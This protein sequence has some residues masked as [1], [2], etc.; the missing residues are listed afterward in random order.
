MATVG[1][2]KV[3]IKAN[4]YRF[5]IYIGM[6]LLIM[7]LS[8]IF[9]IPVLRQILGFIFLTFV[10][11]W[12]I[13]YILKLNKL[14]MTEKL[15][16]CV[17]LSIAF[18]MF[19]GLLI[20]M[21]YP[22]FGYTTPLSTYSVLISFGVITLILAVIAYIRNINT[23]F[24]NISALKLN[25]KE[26]SYLLIPFIF[27]LLSIFGMLVMNS[28]NNNVILMILLCLIAA[29]VIF[30]AIKHNNVPEKIY[31]LTI[32][33]IGIGVILLLALRSNYII[34]VDIHSEYSVF[35]QTLE[36]ERWQILSNSILDSCLSISI[37]PTVYQS[38]LHINSE[39]LFKLLYPLLFSISPLVVYLITKKYLNGFYSFLAS[40]FFISQYYF[41]N[42]EISPR[43][44]I[45]ILFFAL[46]FLVLFANELN[47]GNKYILFIIFAAACIVSHYATTYIFFII[48]V[49]TWILMRIS[50]AIFSTQ[51]KPDVIIPQNTHGD[52]LNSRPAIWS[53][54]RQFLTFIPVAIVFIML[55]IWYSLVTG[56]AFRNGVGFISQTF[57]SLQNF[58][59]MEN[60]GASGT[61]LGVGFYAE[62]IPQQINFVVSWLTVI[63]II[64]GLL[65]V[66][67]KNS[68]FHFLDKNYQSIGLVIDMEYFSLSV[69]CCLILGISLGLPYIF[70]G[71]DLNRTYTLMITILSSFFI[72]GGMFIS[73]I[74]HNKF[75]YL[76]IIIVLIP[77]FLCS[78]GFMYQIFGNPQQIILNSTGVQYDL[79]Y[80]HDQELYADYWLNNN[81]ILSTPIYTDF[82]GQERLESGTNISVNSILDLEN[83]LN[84]QKPL[85]GYIYLGYNAVV[86]GYLDVL[87]NVT[88]LSTEVSINTYSSKIT[89]NDK[90]YSN[91]E[92]DL[93][94]YK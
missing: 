3:V 29:F 92:T 47:A 19:T 52:N 6:F 53:R 14:E 55:F 49:L 72:I 30:I 84:G 24:G 11:G 66:V 56:P 76:V 59:D 81:R 22:L 60:R 32:I 4:T 38:F 73:D 63:F 87:N 77:Y 15:V 5:F 35:Q 40:I 65:D 91:G 17:G 46:A 13:L 41:V 25:V 57:N 58:F 94:Y 69:V 2:T 33:L 12:L 86:D 85:D 67:Y 79:Y 62:T 75:A 7:S 16:L 88:K 36:N 50:P 83:Y 70:I 64:F 23:V 74:I 44:V 48:L 80:F 1:K 28:T 90:I 54:S 39:Y 8:I 89:A 34:G 37:L 43:T 71:Y 18:I 61:A 45:A 78:T 68:R 42:A 82:T 20:N 93:W 51:R 27:P 26:K 9:D 10:P 31:P 21:I